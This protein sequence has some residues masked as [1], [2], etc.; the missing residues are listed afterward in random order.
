MGVTRS[1]TAGPRAVFLDPLGAYGAWAAKRQ[2]ENRDR[3]SG[4]TISAYHYDLLVIGYVN[5]FDGYRDTKDLG[6]KWRLEP[7]IQHR[8]EGHSLF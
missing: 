7:L 8:V 6:I 4:A 2:V 1:F 3:L 5:S